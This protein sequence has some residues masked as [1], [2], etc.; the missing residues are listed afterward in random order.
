VQDNFWYWNSYEM[1]RRLLLTSVVVVVRM[2]REEFATL[3][4]VMMAFVS[5]A[6]QA[7]YTPFKDDEDDL[8]S[9]MFLSNEFFLAFTMFCEENWSW[10]DWSQQPGIFAG[11]MLSVYTC[12]ILL[13]AVR[14]IM[15]RKHG[16]AKA[17]LNYLTTIP[18]QLVC[19]Q[20]EAA[21]G[22]EFR[23]TQVSINVAE[24][25]SQAD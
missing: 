4:V 1:V 13:Y 11:S 19:F 20:H 6:F 9:L 17:V 21:A 14:M 7:M 12:G 23:P 16:T 10:G 25:D 22:S 24:E 15:R 18:R 5:F 2:M 3:Y 8:L